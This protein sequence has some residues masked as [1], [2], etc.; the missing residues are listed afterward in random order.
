[1]P[2]KNRQNDQTTNARRRL[3]LLGPFEIRRAGAIQNL[4]KKAQGLIAYLALRPDDRHPRDHLATLLWGNTATEQARQSLRQCLVALRNAF[5]PN[6]LIAADAAS[7]MLKRGTGL[8]VDVAEFDTLRGSSTLEDLEQACALYRGEFLLGLQIPVEPFNEWVS[9]ERQRLSATRAELLLRCAKA[10]A[11]NGD[12]LG[13]ISMAQDLTAHDP[14]REEGHRLLMRLLTVTGQRGAALKQYDKLNRMLHEELGVGADA[15]SIHLANDIRDG[16]IG[17][18]LE[19]VSAKR[20]ATKIVH[21]ATLTPDAKIEDMRT[22]AVIGPALPEKP[23][24]VVLPFT[25]LSGDPTKDYFVDGLVDDITIALGREKWLFVIAS[26]SAFSFRDRHT[27]P[28]EVA[29][30]LGVRYVLRGSV[31]MNADRL[32]IVIMLT[33]ATSGEFIWSDRFEDD[34]TNVFGLNDQLMSRVA[35]MIAPAVRSVE[36]ER[37]QRKPPANLSTF[38]YYLQAVPKIRSH[39]VENERA[40]ELLEK[41]IALDPSYS[42]AYALAARCYQ[43]QRLMG[44]VPL[45]GMTRERGAGFARLA[46]EL[47]KNDLETLWMAAHALSNLEGETTHAKALIERSLA[48]NPSSASAWSSSCHVH[49]ML[50]EFDKAVEHATLSQRLN[51]ADQLHHVHW[52]IVGMAHLGAARLDEADAAADKALSVSPTY[53]HGLRLKIAT[54]GAL[55]RP[56]EA[57][58]YV[59]RLLVVHPG[60]STAWLEEF[61]GPMM[62]NVPKLL[63]SYLAFSR[64]G[65]MPP[66]KARDGSTLQ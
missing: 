36:I 27:D 46:V 22:S 7:V 40:L 54:C 30:K 60:C 58:K 33:D 59:Q 11:S 52:N 6:D 16:N 3:L 28:R 66:G 55:E 8:S 38:E 9:L 12:M 65:G 44:W 39:L 23:S 10:R 37:A 42:V 64:K 57:R 4:P 63:K 20:A 31:R 18:D 56:A 50:G 32:R 21:A 13:A 26:S 48:L 2:Q 15:D 34:R 43:F 49:T 62:Q 41:A 35:A 24:I 61:Y 45:K 19:G 14:M 17:P 51:P 1:M 53:P 29:A 25:N 5:E 47:G